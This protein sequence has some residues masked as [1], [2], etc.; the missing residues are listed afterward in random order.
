MQSS[1]AHEIQYIEYLQEKSKYLKAIDFF[2]KSQYILSHYPESVLNLDLNWNGD[3]KAKIY[4]KSEFYTYSLDKS[5]TTE[6]MINKLGKKYNVEPIDTKTVT[7]IFASL[8]LNIFPETTL[9]EFL[10]F[11]EPKFKAKFLYNT[12]QHDIP[13]KNKTDSKKPKI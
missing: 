6:D 8:D 3:I 11:L 9:K 7:G 10:E 2:E 13:E 12:L 1:V 4:T 5:V